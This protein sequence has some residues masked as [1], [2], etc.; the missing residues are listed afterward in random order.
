MNIQSVGDAI[1]P[2]VRIT[3]HFSQMNLKYSYE[4]YLNLQEEG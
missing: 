1:C 4:K 3:L 2:R